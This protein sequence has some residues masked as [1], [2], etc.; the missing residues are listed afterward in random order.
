MKQIETSAWHWGGFGYVTQAIT[1]RQHEGVLH[2]I[3]WSGVRRNLL[4]ENSATRTN[5]QRGS[6][7]DTLHDM[8]M[9]LSFVRVH[10]Q[11]LVLCVPSKRSGRLH[12]SW[13]PVTVTGQAYK[14]FFIFKIFRHLSLIYFHPQPSAVRGQLSSFVSG[15]W[16]GVSSVPPR[17]GS[18]SN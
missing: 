12:D 4:E 11:I 16:R 1:T 6:L 15:R 5:R 14:H 8:K 10:K 7:W 3:V 13:R 9:W 17:T 2:K 18:A